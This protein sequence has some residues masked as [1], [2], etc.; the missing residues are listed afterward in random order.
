MRHLLLIALPFAAALLI[1][2][3][4]LEWWSRA[5]TAVFTVGLVLLAG[6]VACCG[7]P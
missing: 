1:A 5:R 7:V 3:T 4:P 2:A 6:L